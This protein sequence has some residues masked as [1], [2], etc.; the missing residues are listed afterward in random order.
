MANE[1][2]IDQLEQS[3]GFLGWTSRG[4]QERQRVDRF[5]KSL[6]EADQQ[7]VEEAHNKEGPGDSAGAVSGG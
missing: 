6:K 3:K 4:M 7:R 5:I 1:K 2:L